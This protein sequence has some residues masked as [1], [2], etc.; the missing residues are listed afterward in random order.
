MKYIK[1]TAEIRAE[2]NDNVERIVERK[3][4]WLDY[5]LMNNQLSQEKY[6]KEVQELNAWAEFATV[7]Y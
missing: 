6:D 4:D 7:R 1:S 2:H 5:K 3:M